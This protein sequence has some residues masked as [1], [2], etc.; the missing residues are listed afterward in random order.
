MLETWWQ[1]DIEKKKRW[2]W[3]KNPGGKD[4]HREK[5]RELRKKEKPTKTKPSNTNVSISK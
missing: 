1:E 3:R 5:T 4:N 2:I